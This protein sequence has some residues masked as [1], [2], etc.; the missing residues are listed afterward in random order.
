MPTL[1]SFPFLSHC[2]PPA[3]AVH[4]IHVHCTSQ[5]HCSRSRPRG[6]TVL[7]ILFTH[8]HTLVNARGH[9]RTTTFSRHREIASLIYALSRRN[10]PPRSA[11]CHPALPPQCR[12]KGSVNAHSWL[13]PEPFS[14]LSSILA[15]SIPLITIRVF[16][17]LF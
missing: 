15:A 5:L 10:F 9:E 17:Y 8:A 11:R 4:V 1:S 12:I 14:S 2:R 16:D 13:F 7:L 6:L 3:E